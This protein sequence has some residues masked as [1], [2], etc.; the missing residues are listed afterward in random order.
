[1]AM[2][3]KFDEIRSFLK[4]AQPM[5][6]AVKNHPVSNCAEYVSDLYFDML[7]VIAQHSDCSA[8]DKKRFICNIMAACNETLTIDEY[9]K[10]AMLM[11]RE[12]TNEFVTQCQKNHLCEIF[13]MDAILIACM[14]GNPDEETLEFIVE[15]SD[16]FGLN[17][18]DVDSI[19]NLALVVLKK[20]FNGLE[21]FAETVSGAE[22]YLNHMEC[23]IT[24]MIEDHVHSDDENPVFYSLCKSNTP[25]FQSSKSFDRLE[26]ITIKNQT[27]N[28]PLNFNSIHTVRLIN[29]TISNYDSG[30][31][32][33]FNNV[34]KAI[35]SNCAIANC[36]TSR[37]CSGTMVFDKTEN[38]EINGGTFK[39]CGNR[40]AV[41][42]IMHIRG[43]SRTNVTIIGA[44]FSNTLACQGGVILASNA[45]FINIYD[46]SFNDCCARICGAICDCE[47]ESTVKA[48]NCDFRNCRD[49][50]EALFYRNVSY[51]EGG[52]HYSGCSSVV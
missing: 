36:N 39:N 1:M 31:V 42:G 18:N 9:Y 33:S 16:A 48:L 21:N 13:F 24:P 52:C 43:A 49:D 27:I 32:L 26:S 30:T 11:D 14:N 29:C 23:Y 7:S 41:G 4:D 10:R 44:S 51:Y 28:K 45:S 47:F 6:N 35:L 2:Q 20:D 12:K 17:K 46:S 5:A 50:N 25:F 15:F 38:I 34:E 19:T 40:E 8:D 3:S 37:T 22:Q